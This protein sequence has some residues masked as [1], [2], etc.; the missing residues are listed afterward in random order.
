MKFKD[1]Y[2]IGAHYFNLQRV[3]A[4]TIDGGVGDVAR[5]DG[6]IRI[7]TDLQKSHQEQ[8]L[9]HEVLHMINNEMDEKEIEYLSQAI[10]LFLSENDMLK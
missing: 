7:S 3:P 4:C 9:F 2:K 10:Y 8:T 5:E 1:Q 6:V